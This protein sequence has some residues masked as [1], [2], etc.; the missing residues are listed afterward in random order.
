MYLAND[1]LMQYLE[2]QTAAR[3]WIED[4]LEEQTGDDLSESLRDGIVLC[5]L[6]SVCNSRH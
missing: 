3:Q 4:L 1:L 6:I 2:K 5:R